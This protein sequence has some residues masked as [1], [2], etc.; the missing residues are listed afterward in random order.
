MLYKWNW[1]YTME[2]VFLYGCRSKK[3]LEK[4]DMLK[5]TTNLENIF[6]VVKEL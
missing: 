4:L 5:I 3:K 1:K 2:S 6:Y